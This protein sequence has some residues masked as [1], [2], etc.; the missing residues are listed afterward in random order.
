[1][2]FRSYRKTSEYSLRDY[3]AKVMVIMLFLLLLYLHIA[4]SYTLTIYL[5]FM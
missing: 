3:V 5:L 4:M 1:M 2:M